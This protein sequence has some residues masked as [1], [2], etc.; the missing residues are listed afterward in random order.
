[1]NSAFSPGSRKKRRRANGP[2][3]TGQKKRARVPP[4]RRRTKARA[5]LARYCF[6]Q[7][8]DA[9]FRK[10]S[11]VR[12]GSIVWKRPSLHPRE[13]VEHVVAGCSRRVDGSRAASHFSGDWHRLIDH[14]RLFFAQHESPTVPYSCNQ[15]QRAP[16]FT[17]RRPAPS[18]PLKSAR[19]ITTVSLA[20]ISGS[21]ISI[22]GQIPHLLVDLRV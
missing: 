12:R 14:G 21:Q 2:A 3:A 18:R 9:P 10:L 17:L 20:H 22:N 11:R 7:M 5:C 15:L 4:R 13:S 1:M 19:R 16:R 6:W 8:E